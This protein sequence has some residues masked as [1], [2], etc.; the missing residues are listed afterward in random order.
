MLVKEPIVRDKE[1]DSGF[2][3]CFVFLASRTFLQA[4]EGMVAL[5]KCLSLGKGIS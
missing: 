3:V 4:P 2:V 5:G 1:K